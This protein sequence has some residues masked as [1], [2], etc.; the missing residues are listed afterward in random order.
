MHSRAFVPGNLITEPI[1]SL[2]L[3]LAKQTL[4]SAS[5]ILLVVQLVY[6]L[7]ID[8]PLKFMSN[9]NKHISFLNDSIL[10]DQIYS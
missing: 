3:T 10:N 4:L 9:F 2:C 5:Y 7:L 8:L 1:V 6:E